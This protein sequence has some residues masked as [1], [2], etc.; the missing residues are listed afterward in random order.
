LTTGRAASTAARIIWFAAVRKV[1]D[2]YFK[3]AK[4]ENYPARSV[5]KLEEAQKRYG[6]LRPGDS[7][8]D[9]GCQPGSWSLYAA[10][11][12][13]VQGLLVGVDLQAGRL[14]S[15]TGGARIHWLQDDIM[16]P[17]LAARLR[18]FRPLYRVVLSDI[19][20]RTTGN[21]WVD[22]QHSLRLAR[23]TLEIA[24]EFLVNGGNY[25]VKVFQGEDFTEFVKEVQDIFKVVKIVK[26]KS[27]RTE[28]REVFVLGMGYIKPETLPGAAAMAG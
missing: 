15:Q 7:V 28:S 19:A 9:L 12:V 5:Y 27:S 25:F 8:L 21:K 14:A 22:Q 13:G 20:P 23:R 4:Q 11:V 6:L 2:H 26:P 10:K 1:Q 18:E 3:K 16:A 24:R 17:E